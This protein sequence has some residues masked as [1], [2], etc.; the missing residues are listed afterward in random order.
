[1]FSYNITGLTSGTTYYVRVSAANVKGYGSYIGTTP[2][3][4][5]PKALPSAPTGLVIRHWN[6]S[7]LEA[8]VQLAAAGNGD[9]VASY[10]LQLDTSNAFNSAN[11]KTRTLT[12]DFTVQHV[13]SAA[14]FGPIGGTFTL[15]V[16]DFAGDFTVQIGGALFD[17]VQGTS[18]LL[19]A[20]SSVAAPAFT[21]VIARR[22]LLKVCMC[23]CCM[24]VVCCVCADAFS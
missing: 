14:A 11:L 19:R 6:N 20:A 8:E 2:S 13:T 7:A 21:S 17:V 18:T 12:P 23:V 4:V 16:G 1:V 5:A 22:D 9:T 24:R 15:A 10:L 3:G